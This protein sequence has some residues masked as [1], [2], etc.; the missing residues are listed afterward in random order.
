MFHLSGC[1]HP[2]NSHLWSADNPNT[3][4]E[5][6][7]HDHNIGAWIVI[8]SR[9]C[10]DPI[11]FAE[12]LKSDCYCQII[13]QFIGELTGNADSTMWHDRAYSRTVHEVSETVFRRSNHFQRPPSFSDLSPPDIHNF[14]SYDCRG[15]PQAAIYDFTNNIPN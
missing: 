1:V 6:P 10:V 11:L 14:W 13:Y 2:H 5:I 9:R 8:S 12:T 7:Q 15:N 3:V 4:H